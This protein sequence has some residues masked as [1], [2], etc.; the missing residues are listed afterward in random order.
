MTVESLFSS[1]AVA[2]LIVAVMLVEAILLR[3]HLRKVP[4]IAFGLGAGASLALA[5]WAALSQQGWPLVAA[6]LLLSF[7]FHILEIRQW[8][9]IAHRI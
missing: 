7:V 2:W 8:L 6:F 1:G 5:L 4:L 3:R 9:S